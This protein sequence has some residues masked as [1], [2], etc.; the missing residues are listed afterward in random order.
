MWL[1][2]S[3]L[4]VGEVARQKVPIKSDIFK[5]DVMVVSP[6]FAIEL[7]GQDGAAFVSEVDGEDVNIIGKYSVKTELTKSM[8]IQGG[9]I[10]LNRAS[11]LN[12][13]E[14]GP[15]PED[16][17]EGEENAAATAKG[18]EVAMDDSEDGVGSKR[19]ALPTK[20]KRKNKAKGSRSLVEA[21]TMSN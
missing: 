21:E 13:L 11:E 4:S 20:G 16:V 10:Q 5:K 1:L 8:Y 12:G 17:E 3:G 7:G 6:T 14:Y 15:Y 18:K 19:K 2:S 9:K